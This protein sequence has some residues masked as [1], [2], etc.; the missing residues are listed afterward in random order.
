MKGV[1]LAAGIGKR[2]RPVTDVVPKPMVPI[3]N[4]PVLEHVVRGLAEAGVDDI[5]VVV[6]YKQEQIRAY[7]GDGTRFGVSLRYL[8][9]EN[10]AGGT[11]AA[12]LLGEEFVADEPFLLTFGDLMLSPANYRALVDSYRQRPTSGRITANWMEDPS[13]GAAVTIA[14]D[15]RLVRIVEKP[16]KGTAESNWNNAGI[17]VFT[18]D[19]FAAIR[20]I[21]LSPRGELELTAAIQLLADERG[22]VTVY[23]LE[24]L[25]SDVGNPAR[26]LALNRAIL[27]DTTLGVPVARCAEA[28]GQAVVE[29]NCAVA[30]GAELASCQ[31][32]EHSCVAAGT[33]V[34]EGAV[35]RESTICSG[36]EVGAGC[37]LEYAIVAPGA[38]VADGTEL[39]GTPEQPA[40]AI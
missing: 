28:S 35:L 40:V 39:R 12:A 11:G 36:G 4:R 22:D 16:P 27:T 5:L 19:I 13:A 33:R 9:Q 17:F 20:R 34:R 29:A 2:M 1:V 30:A 25:W 21:P 31:V 26:V 32:L 14:D 38:R 7:F 10:P 8:H 18:P 6:N 15:E 37:R 3:V 23:R 24:G